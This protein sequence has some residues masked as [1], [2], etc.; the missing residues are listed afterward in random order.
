MKLHRIIF[1]FFLLLINVLEA[2]NPV[3]RQATIQALKIAFITKELNLTAEEAQRFWPVYN[4]YIDDLRKL[5]KEN[6]DDVLVFEERSLAIKKKYNVDFKR[7]L[8]S[9]ERANKVFLADRNFAMFI[10]KELQDRQRLRSLRQ[11]F[12][13]MDKNNKPA[14]PQTDY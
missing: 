4:T 5:R 2:Q 6:K 12:G 7:I 3:A 9:E 8:S 13:D 1:I 11:G 14:T 10:K